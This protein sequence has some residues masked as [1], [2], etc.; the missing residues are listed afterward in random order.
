VTS[1]EITDVLSAFY[2]EHSASSA[3]LK[4]AQKLPATLSACNSRAQWQLPVEYPIP[5]RSFLLA[6]DRGRLNSQD[7]RSL[8]DGEPS[9]ESKLNNPALLRV[10]HRQSG[11]GLV[12]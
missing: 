4:R 9:K 8:F 7:F 10:E 6:F 3:A 12:D 5:P 11:Q 2:V 1:D